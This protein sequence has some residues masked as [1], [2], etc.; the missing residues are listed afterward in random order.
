MRKL[1]NPYSP[2]MCFLRRVGDIILLNLLW[3]ICC[4]PIVTIGVSTGAMN[5]VAQ[6]LQADKCD[7][8]IKRF[9]HAVCRDWKQ[10]AVMG[11]IFL[12]AG[13]V[14]WLDVSSLLVGSFPGY[15]LVVMVAAPLVVIFAADY[16][17]PLLAHFDNTIGGTLKNALLLAVSNLPRTILM[18]L[19]NLIPVGLLLFWPEAFWYSVGFWVLIGGALLCYI[20]TRL[21]RPVFEKLEPPQENAEE[22]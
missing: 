14:I 11:L 21:L 16:A 5:A 8:V 6:E 15:L 3:V 9:F 17:F 2:L 18:S 1:F 7:G 19:V 4:V 10:T 22:N 20:N 12:A 13:A